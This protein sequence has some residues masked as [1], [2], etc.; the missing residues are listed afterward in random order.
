VAHFEF[1][2]TIRLI[3][4]K[5]LLKQGVALFQEAVTMPAATS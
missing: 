5:K 3:V 2:I 1:L 4:C